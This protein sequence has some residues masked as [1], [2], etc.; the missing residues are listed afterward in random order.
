MRNSLLLLILT[1]LLMAV[2][3]GDGGGPGCRRDGESYEYPGTGSGS[4]GEDYTPPGG[5]V[6]AQGYTV[7]SAGFAQQSQLSMTRTGT[8]TFEVDFTYAEPHDDDIILYIRENQ[9][10]PHDPELILE[11]VS[12]EQVRSQSKA[13]VTIGAG[14]GARV[15]F[16]SLSFYWGCSHWHSNAQVNLTVVDLTPGWQALGSPLGQGPSSQGALVGSQTQL[17]AAAV[18]DVGGSGSGTIAPVF[19][20]SAPYGVPRFDPIEEHRPRLPSEYPSEPRL[21]LDSQGNLYV[22]R[23]YFDWSSGQ[24]TLRVDRL[25]SGASKLEPLSESV[26]GTLSY[27]GTTAL[28]VDSQGRPVIAWINEWQAHVSVWNSTAQGG[29]RFDPP[30]LLT[31][32]GHNTAEL[33]LVAGQRIHVLLADTDGSGVRALISG[34]DGAFTSRGILSPEQTYVSTLS[35]A[36]AS[37]GALLA[38]FLESSATGSPRVRVKRLAA[39][40]LASAALD[41]SPP[42][43]AAYQRATQTT[44][45]VGRAGELWLGVHQFSSAVEAAETS[46]SAWNGATWS[47]LTLGLAAPA[48]ASSIA[49]AHGPSGPVRLLTSTAPIA[50]SVYRP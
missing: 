10:E 28:A 40:A 25:P 8:L 46:V 43:D 11:D 29:A 33:A 48:D 37:D 34:D 30:T 21:A 4:G 49:V 47:K 9:G 50:P 20:F 6:T 12:P 1:P 13:T 7:T 41:L 31:E 44:L 22:S 17:F 23:L 16:H 35:A 15:G 39:G 24:A 32:A 45:T 19:R 42:T 3:C 38:A 5:G 27:P 18:L 26:A 36:L 14:P 2:D